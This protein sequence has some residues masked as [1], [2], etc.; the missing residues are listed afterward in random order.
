LANFLGREKWLEYL[1]DHVGRHP[2]SGVSHIDRN[3]IAHLTFPTT[4]Q[5]GVGHLSVLDLD[6]EF[7]AIGHGMAGVDCQ[8]QD[9]VLDLPRICSD[10]PEVIVGCDVKFHGFAKGTIEQVIHSLA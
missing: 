8:V 2:G 3:I 10:L 6:R 1:G 5:S 4:G 9:G 7:P